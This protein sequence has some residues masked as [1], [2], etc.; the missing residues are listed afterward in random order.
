MVGAASLWSCF[1]AWEAELANQ[2]SA[3]TRLAR[4]AT[5]IPPPFVLAYLHSDFGNAYL[6]AHARKRQ[7]QKYRSLGMSASFLRFAHISA[8]LHSLS[9]W[10]CISGTR[11][12]LSWSYAFSRLWFILPV[13][14]PHRLGAYVAAD[15]RIL[16][17]SCPMQYLPIIASSTV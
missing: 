3:A 11:R 10:R 12:N 2:L 9:G 15:K 16:H 17:F 4:V 5:P 7:R 13:Y 14:T 8:L 1:R 6:C